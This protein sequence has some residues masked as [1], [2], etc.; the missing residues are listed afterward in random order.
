M[1]RQYA[2]VFWV[3]ININGSHLESIKIKEREEKKKGGRRRRKREFQKN[4]GE[5]IGYRERDGREIGCGRVVGGKDG[6]FCVL[7]V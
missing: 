4:E 3:F 6:E 1:L 2:G 5:K 7:C